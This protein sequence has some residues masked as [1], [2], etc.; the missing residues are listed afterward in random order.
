MEGIQQHEAKVWSLE[1]LTAGT[2]NRWNS[3]HTNL[4]IQRLGGKG[5]CH[6]HATRAGQKKKTFCIWTMLTGYV[7]GTANFTKC[8]YC[9]HVSH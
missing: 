4:T 9:T 5:Q 7:V 6:L 8:F 3:S 2:W 1:G